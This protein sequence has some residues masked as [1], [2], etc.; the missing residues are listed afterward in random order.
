MS[1]LD[2]NTVGGD[3]SVDNVGT[4]SVVGQAGEQSDAVRL[5]LEKIAELEKQVRSLTSEKEKL[6]TENT[7][8]MKQQ[9]RQNSPQDSA[10]D[11]QK[12]FEDYVVGRTVEWYKYL[13]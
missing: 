5:A 3:S 4:D 11:P 9:L 6:N 13:Q 7:E 10:E 2:D 8:L 12:K 1:D